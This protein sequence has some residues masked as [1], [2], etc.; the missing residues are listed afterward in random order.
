MTSSVFFFIVVVVWQRRHTSKDTD[1]KFK[2]E[3]ASC[4]KKPRLGV[5]AAT[6]TK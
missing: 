6:V 3:A 5:L 2:L 1:L 4:R